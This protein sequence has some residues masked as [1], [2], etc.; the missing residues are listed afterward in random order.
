M[1]KKNGD[2]T[3]RLIDAAIDYEQTVHALLAFAALVTHNG[4][5][6]REGAEFGLGRRMTP[7]PVPAPTADNPEAVVQPDDVTPDLVAQ[8]T[9]T[10]GIVAEA[11]KSLDRDGHYEQHIQQL[12]KYDA[13]LAGWWTE[14]EQI[15]HSDA[16]I[17]VHQSRGRKF[18]RYFD[19]RRVRA[20][21]SVGPNSSVI[22]FNE[23]TERV[24][25]YFFRLAAGQVGD[26]ELSARLDEGVNIPIDEV[27]QSFGNVRYYDYRPPMVLLL[28]RL[29][30][31][32]LPSLIP[33]GKYDEQTGK[34]K[35]QVSI[36]AVTQELQAA[37]GSAVLHQDQRAVQFP[38]TTWIRR[39][40]ERLVE[41]QLALPPNGDDDFYT[42][43]YGPFKK[44]VR[45]RFAELEAEKGP[46]EA[47]AEGQM[48]LFGEPAG[49]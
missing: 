3:A 45:E 11:K 32:Y 9:A 25:Y 37:N 34:H 35:L 18:A 15:Q 26:P 27:L 42:V 17:L 43:F 44:D 49:M 48:L 2:S 46:A 39:A 8:K 7:A 40:L 36:A 21:D 41:H 22:E 19:E 5:S 6:K 1:T 47:P 14:S 23:S 4:V 28:E 12:R 31:D 24:P 10:Y 38:T 29:W 20:D 16:A 33:D 30:V 13:A